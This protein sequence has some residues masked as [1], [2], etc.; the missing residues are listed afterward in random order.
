[1][2]QRLLQRLRRQGKKLAQV[3]RTWARG[4]LD[5]TNSDAHHETDSEVDAALAAF[6]LCRGTGDGDAPP[7]VASATKCYLWP[8]N[9]DT[10]R[11]WQRMQTQWRYDAAGKR[12]GLEYAGVIRFLVDIQG[13][14][15]KDRAQLFGGLQAMESAALAVWDDRA[16]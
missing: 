15:P 14:K 4:Q 5:L 9:V 2:F 10:F 7:A 11:L 12:T 3:A 13:V 6:G 8:C 16:G 1:M